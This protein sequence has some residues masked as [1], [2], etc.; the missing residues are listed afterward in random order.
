MSRLEFSPAARRDLIEIGDYI[1]RD[2]AA[3]ARR[4]VGKLKA[5]CERISK[6]P[7]AYPF[8]DREAGIRFAPIG[9]YLIFFRAIGESVRIER[10]LHSARHLP[11]TILS[12]VSGE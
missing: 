7:S 9:R 10:I 6:M 1:A 12:A 3:S 5:Q 8:R 4:F 2:S 11:V